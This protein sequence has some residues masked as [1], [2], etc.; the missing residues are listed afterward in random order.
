MSVIRQQRRTT[1]TVV[2]NESIKDERLSLRA[3]G[4]HLVLLSKPDH[5][6][7]SSERLAAECREGRD[8]IRTALRELREAGYVLEV[9]E[10]GNGGQWTTYVEVNEVA[11]DSIPVSNQG[12]AGVVIRPKTG[13]QSSANRGLGEPSSGESGDEVKT[14]KQELTVRTP[15]H[16]KAAPE[17]ESAVGDLPSE[18][19]DETTEDLVDKKLS[20]WGLAKRFTNKAEAMYP[21]KPAAYVAKR[22][23]Q[24]NITAWQTSGVELEVVKAA[25]DRFF[26]DARFHEEHKPLWQSFVN[27]WVDLADRA[28]RTTRSNDTEDE[29]VVM[30]KFG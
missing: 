16:R 18:P 22:G 4:L 19:A 27:S 5:W 3:K 21:G 13:F 12:R 10:Q 15:R 1:F 9:R 11:T 14:D 6:E 23:L 7:F 28:E 25:I 8:A 29:A 2:D 30:V 26:T 17:D 20:A 24:K